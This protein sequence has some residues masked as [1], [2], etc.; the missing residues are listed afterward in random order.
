MRFDTVLNYIITYYFPKNLASCGVLWMK[1][2]CV[3]NK[4]VVL[5]TLV[6]FVSEVGKCVVKDAG[7]YRNRKDGLCLIL[8]WGAVSLPLLQNSCM[9]QPKSF[10]TPIS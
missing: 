5:R 3:V 4:D 2:G 9:M 6:L 7:D 8:P 1:Q 10:K